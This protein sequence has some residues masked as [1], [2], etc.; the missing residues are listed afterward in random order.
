MRKRYWRGDV[1]IA[2][3][4]LVFVADG[5][6]E[7]AP[8]FSHTIFKRRSKKK[9]TFLNK[10]LTLWLQYVIINININRRS[11]RYIMPVKEMMLWNY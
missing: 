4:V 2:H 7:F 1:G 3:Y 6:T 8:T 5:R 9:R 11:N 10:R